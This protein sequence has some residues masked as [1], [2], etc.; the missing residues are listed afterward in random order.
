MLKYALHGFREGQEKETDTLEANLTQ[1]L[2]RLSHDPF[3]QVLLD[4]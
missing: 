1:Q 4:V 3:L 2:D